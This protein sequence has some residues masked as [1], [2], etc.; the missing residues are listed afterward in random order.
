MLPALGCCCWDCGGCWNP[1]QR[2]GLSSSP[3]RKRL[4]PSPAPAS[5][6]HGSL[7]SPLGFLIPRDD[8]HRSCATLIL[9]GSPEPRC[10]RSASRIPPAPRLRPRSGSGLA[11]SSQPFAN[12]IRKLG[13]PAADSC[14]FLPIPA[15]LLS[16]CRDAVGTRQLP[17]QA[18]DEGDVTERAA[19]WPPCPH[20]R[21]GWGARHPPA[22][23]LCGSFIH[24]WFSSRN[25]FFGVCDSVTFC[26][27]FQPPKPHSQSRIPSYF[28]CHRVSALRLT[29]VIDALVT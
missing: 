3:T 25:S 21:P 19:A 18:P 7:V 14:P 9:A 11:T 13:R 24:A 10:R 29:Y 5:L 6:P 8:C 28:R 27:L 26:V 1:P 15:A 17:A 20:L 4:S 22:R 16:T 23:S 12:C 2:T